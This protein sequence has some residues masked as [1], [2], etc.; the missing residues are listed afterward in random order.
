MKAVI[1]AGGLG[2]RI[3]EETQSKP[4]PLIEIGGFFVLSPNIFDYIQGDSTI[5]GKEPLETL[6]QKNQLAAYNPSGFW[7]PL[8]TLQDKNYLEGLCNSD[9]VLWKNKI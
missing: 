8:D 4:K 2:T 7:Q 9:N 6:T 3:S 1:L 5:W